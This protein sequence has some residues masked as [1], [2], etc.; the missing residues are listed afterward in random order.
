VAGAKV[1]IRPEAIPD[2]PCLR[3]E[4]DAARVFVVAV[5][6][7]KRGRWRACAGKQQLFR[8]EIGVHGAVEIQV[9]A[10]Q[11]GEDRGVEVQA[12]HPAQRQGM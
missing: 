5:E 9:V 8:G 11:V 4:F 12:I 1:R 7:G 2:H 10:G 3:V 6:H